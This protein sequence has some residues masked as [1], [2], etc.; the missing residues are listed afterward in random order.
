MTA[1]K[2]KRLMALVKK[3]TG[4]EV[5]MDLDDSISTRAATI[6]ATDFFPMHLVKVH[7]EY[8]RYGDYLVA[9]Q[10]AFLLIKWGKPKQIPEFTPL[11]DPVRPLIKKT[12]RMVENKGFDPE[13]AS[14]FAGTVVGGVLQQLN[15]MP[16]QL[17]GMEMVAEL[18]PALKPLQAEAVENE[19]QE[20]SGNFNKDV[21]EI[22][23]KVIFD[24]VASMNSAYAL[25]WS[26]LSGNENILLPYRSDGFMARGKKLICLYELKAKGADPDRYVEIVDG[27]AKILKMDHMYVWNYRK[28]A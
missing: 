12:A 26:Q 23:P 28:A 11:A 25:R 9:L 24:R 21:K 13:T 5:S 6:S 19:F 16:I 8:E 20:I 3:K 14:R 1:A 2:V 15:S 7:P 17:I 4:Y 18:S 27:W 10:C 22:I